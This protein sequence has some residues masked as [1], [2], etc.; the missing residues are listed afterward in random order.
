MMAVRMET[1]VAHDFEL[2]GGDLALDF[3][4]TVGGMRGVKPRE[5]LRDYADLLAF[6]RQTGAIGER[7]GA[8]LASEAR[9]RPEEAAAALT[10]A[11]GVREA[12]YRIFVECAAGRR[13]R[14]PDLEVLNAALAR[15]LP[16]RRV[17]QQEGGLALS[18]EKEAAFEAPLWPVVDAAACLLTAGEVER[19]RVC[20]MH[21]EEE[22]SWVFLDRTKGRT[23]RWCSMK[24]C[25]NRSK[26]RRHYAKVKAQGVAV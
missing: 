6:A 15:A 14:V 10:G 3:I 4:N 2:S 25:G 13:P 12:L 19:V 16:H 8:R 26:A 22:C 21:E 9:R 5:Y 23:R 11:I 7:Q 20:G 18:W 17:V 1:R 24:D